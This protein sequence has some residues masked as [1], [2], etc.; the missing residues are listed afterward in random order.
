MR[1]RVGV[2][3]NNWT[4]GRAAKS[5]LDHYSACCFYFYTVLSQQCTHMPL[6]KVKGFLFLSRSFKERC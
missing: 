4:G 1:V 3:I 2:E 5:E 6:K